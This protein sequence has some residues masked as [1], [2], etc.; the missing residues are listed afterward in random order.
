MGMTDDEKR[1]LKRCG[2]A[3]DLDGLP[4]RVPRDTAAKLVSQYFFQVSPRSMERWNLAWRRVN[5]R[6]HCETADA[7]A[8]A[9]SMLD[10]AP[11]VMGGRRPVAEEE[12]A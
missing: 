8:V 1:A 3:P 7:F 11:P 9:K 6:A 4:V 12:S 5:G 10:A 2:A